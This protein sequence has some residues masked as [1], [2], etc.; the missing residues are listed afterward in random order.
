MNV[1]TDIQ[2][3]HDSNGA[4]AF[5]VLPYA[6]WLAGRDRQES[7]VPNEVVN[8]TFDNDWTPMRAWRE[9]LG[10]TQAEVASRANM[11]QGAYAQME[12]SAKPRRASLKKI[13]KAMGLTVEQL[14][15]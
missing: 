10:L 15:F 6:D 7:L 11:T 13:A 3:I 5:V 1:H 12:K 9:H 4:P 2:I 8:L 14:D